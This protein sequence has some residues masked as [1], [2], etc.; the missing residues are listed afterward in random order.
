MLPHNDV[1]KCNFNCKKIMLFGLP[2]KPVKNFPQK[3]LTEV[4][5]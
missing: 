1:V 3:M 5:Y 2:C 4:V